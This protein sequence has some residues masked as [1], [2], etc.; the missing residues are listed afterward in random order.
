[1]ILITHSF[2]AFNAELLEWNLVWKR[3]DG[4]I[5]AQILVTKKWK[6]MKPLKSVKRNQSQNSW[7]LQD[8][9]YVVCTSTIFWWRH[10]ILKL[11]KSLILGWFWVDFGFETFTKAWFWVDLSVKIIIWIR[12]SSCLLNVLVGNLFFDFDKSVWFDL[13]QNEKLISTSSQFIASKLEV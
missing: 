1:M 9:E 8:I 6:T 10:I 5:L 11:L 2:I 7:D 13:E 12:Q 4:Q 3:L